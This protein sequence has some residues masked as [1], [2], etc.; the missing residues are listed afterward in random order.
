MSEEK[1]K[2]GEAKLTNDL[3]VKHYPNNYHSKVY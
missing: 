1:K 3:Y 2:M